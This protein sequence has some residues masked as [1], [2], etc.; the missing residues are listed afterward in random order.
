MPPARSTSAES[1]GD[2]DVGG[3]VAADPAIVVGV[4]AADVVVAAVDDVAGAAVGCFVLE[5]DV[6]AN[7]TAASRPIRMTTA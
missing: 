3:I 4:A 6:N 5:H 2:G 1:D 7:A